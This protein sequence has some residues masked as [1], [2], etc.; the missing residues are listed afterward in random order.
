MP[1]IAKKPFIVYR[2]HTGLQ[3]AVYY[4]GF[5]NPT[6]RGYEKRQVLKDAQG[7]NVTSGKIAELLAEEIWTK[8]VGFA[9]AAGFGTFLENFWSPNAYA[10]DM[11][12]KGEPLSEVYRRNSLNA[13]KKHVRP[14]LRDVGKDDLPVDRVLPEL[15]AAILRAASDKGLKGRTVNT[16]RQAIGVPLGVYWKGKKH[17]ELNPCQFVDRYDEKPEERE[18]FTLDEARKFFAR[19]W[20]DPRMLAINLQGAFTGMRLGECL[21]THHDDIQE[22][23]MR[24][25]KRAV[26]E[27][28]LPVR[29]NWQ[30]AEGMKSPKKGSFGEVPVPAEIARRLLALRELSPWARGAEP[31]TPL[32]L[33]WGA[34]ASR[35]TAKEDVERE[36]NAACRD[37]GIDDA[38]RKRRGLGFH[39]WRH[40][41]DSHVH[42]DPV[43]MQKLLRHATPEMTTHYRH[44]TEE[45]RRAASKA[46][47]GLAGLIGPG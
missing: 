4:A 1:R 21:G 22:H 36:Y 40:W 13:V 19:K 47:Q 41:F 14:Y 43:V 16:V 30:A 10:K 3:Q 33:Y 24:V 35:P 29:H 44:M 12:N 34:R 37:I 7:R 15:I 31:G 20:T 32:F 18:I 45:Q 5:L 17:P 11:R 42:I 25:G 8:G 38:E 26:T 27:Y 46:V 39:A 2:R 6:T 28:W 9:G 23:S